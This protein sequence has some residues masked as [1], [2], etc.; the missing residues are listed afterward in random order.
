MDATFESV[1]LWGLFA[2]SFLSATLLPGN[3][4]LALVALLHHA[5]ELKWSALAVATFGNTLGGFTSYLIG[6]LFPRPRDG[7]AAAWMRR[8]GAPALLLA[9]APLIGDALCVAAG[10]LRQN[11][12]AA[13]LFMAVGKFARYWVLATGLELLS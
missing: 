4:E 7:R 2:S 6:R 8:Y 9:W 3:S 11:A 10:W 5:P 13:L 12:A 1:G